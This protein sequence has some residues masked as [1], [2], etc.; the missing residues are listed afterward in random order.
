[1]IVM[2]PKIARATEEDH[3]AGCSGL[4]P[5]ASNAT[6]SAIGAMTSEMAMSERC[7]VLCSLRWPGGVIGGRSGLRG[8]R[9]HLVPA[10]DA[11]PDLRD[12]DDDRADLQDA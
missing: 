5:A 2:P 6:A 8:G 12:E 11:W 10:V 9:A 4:A 7:M 3:Q 1:M